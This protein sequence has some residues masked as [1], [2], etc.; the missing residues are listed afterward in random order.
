MKK[1]QDSNSLSKL[2]EKVQLAFQNPIRED[3]GGVPGKH[4]NKI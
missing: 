2:K 1:N 4:Y 3:F